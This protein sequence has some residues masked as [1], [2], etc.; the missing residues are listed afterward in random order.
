MQTGS[1]AFAPSVIHALYVRLETFATE[2][3]GQGEER[4]K[5]KKKGKKGK[6]L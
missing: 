6:V 2:S 3:L 1:R 4:E 5:I